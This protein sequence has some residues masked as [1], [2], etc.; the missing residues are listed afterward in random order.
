MWNNTQHRQ[1][2]HEEKPLVSFV[3]PVF[4]GERYISRCLSSIQRL[5][6]L[7]EAYE[8]IVVDNGSTDRTTHIVR[9]LG[10]NCLVVP[11]VH[12]SALRNQGVARTQGEFIAFVDADVEVASDW[13]QHG[14][15][16]FKDSRVVASGCFPRVPQE[17]TWVQ[18]AWD[19]HQR[20]R[21]HTHTP[22]SVSWLPS[23]NLIVRREAFLAVSGFN[24]QLTTAEDVDLCYRMAQHGT[25]LW[26]P[27]MEAIHWG[28]ARDLRTFWRKESWRSIS[29]LSG[30]WSHGLRWD[31]LP[32]LGYPLYV[33]CGIVFF[34]LS[35][36]VDLRQ[37]QCL[38]MPLSLILLILPALGLALNTA[39]LSRQPRLTFQFLLLYFIY[40]LARAYAVLKPW[41]VQYH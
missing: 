32:S 6:F 10:F 29:N 7:P 40:G 9:E 14:L 26:N 31:E 8:V 2:I 41:I 13:L 16:V 24:E 34:I 17:A 12:V 36:I 39:R 28:E 4:N 11:K 20:G 25:I 19:V 30:V 15:A 3:I 18:K 23:M 22:R 21:Q 5:H 1:G 37:G 33:L 38:L 35:T 27:A